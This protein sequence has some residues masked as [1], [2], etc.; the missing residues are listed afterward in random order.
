MSRVALIYTP[1]GGGHRAAAQ[2]VAG[3]LRG[4]EVVNVLDF[5]PRWF[6]YDR[7]WSL[8]Q[9]RGRHAWDWLFDASDRGLDLDA[10]RLPLNR[11]LFRGLDRWLLAAR[12]THIVCTHYLPA[13]AAVRVKEQLGARVVV[14]ITDHLAHRAWIV[15]GVD[16]YCVAD[17]AVAR[18]VRRRCDA[19]VH[20][21]GIP[22]ARA[23]GAPV[24]AVPHDTQRANI[25][26]LLGGV[27]DGDAHAAIDALAP[28][29]HRHELEVLCGDS[30]AVL[31]HAR[32]V[33]GRGEPR[34][35]G[36]LAAIDRAHLVVTKAGGLTVSECLARGRAM[37]MPFAAPGQERGN[38]MHALEA[39]AAMRTNEIADLAHVVDRIAGEPGRLRRMSAQA[40]R[41]SRPYA[42]ADVADVVM[43]AEGVR[44]VA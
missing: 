33:L 11:A 20:V 34:T 7:A 13:L 35:N 24:V 39:G 19:E 23:A 1:A 40:R 4:A 8:I 42:A 44:H 27:P 21:T 3:E 36:L 22:V 15:P 26:V 38:L 10:V 25:L 2:A 6:A 29:A 37:V 43:A 30:P 28:L 16:A 32:E 14:T 31:R 12:P 18:S 5:A 41:A 17:D 9:R